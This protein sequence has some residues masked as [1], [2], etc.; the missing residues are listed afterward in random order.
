MGQYGAPIEMK[1]PVAISSFQITFNFV[2]S[3][4]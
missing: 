3:F 2:K 4:S 1:Q